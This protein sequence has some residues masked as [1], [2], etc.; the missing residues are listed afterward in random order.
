MSSSV[1]MAS[2]SFRLKN[3]DQ[4]FANHGKYFTD[5][6]EALSVVDRIET[7]LVTERAGNDGDWE[8]GGELVVTYYDVYMHV[9]QCA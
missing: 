7:R 2:T 6:S 4:T 5:L 3:P 1:R 8:G 9:R